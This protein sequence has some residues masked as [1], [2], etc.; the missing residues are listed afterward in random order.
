M[1]E[2]SSR[3]PR[4][5]PPAWISIAVP[6]RLVGVASSAKPSPIT[7]ASDGTKAHQRPIRAPETTKVAGI[8]TLDRVELG[9]SS[10]TPIATHGSTMP[11]TITMNTLADM[12]AKTHRRY[13]GP[14][15]DQP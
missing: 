5:N 13:S 4:L 6:V 9:T 1:D 2:I 8:S 7:V 14:D 10:P 11:T 12:T 15:R 3:K